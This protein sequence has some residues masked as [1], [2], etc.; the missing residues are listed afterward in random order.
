MLARILCL[1]IVLLEVRGLMLSIG[2]RRWKVF[3]Y[4][5]QLSNMVTVL[6]AAL[7]VSAG[8]T[9]FVSL[10]RYVSSCMLVMTFFVTACILVPMGGDPKQLLF[11]GN[12]FYHHLVIPIVS[13][14]S[15]LFAER[16]VR[17][18]AAVL[19]P[20]AITFLYGMVMLYLN[21]LDVFD[22]PYP[23]FRAKDQPV[24]ATVLWM[25]ALT[26]VIGLISLAVYALGTI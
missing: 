2:D 9:P 7:A 25:A 22:G 18:A 13:V 23:F 3:A 21:Y 8:Q 14:G 24:P 4:Y 15:Y 1:I 5:T 16:H 19:L 12:G 17:T 6:S 20:T 11:S 10:L 26:G